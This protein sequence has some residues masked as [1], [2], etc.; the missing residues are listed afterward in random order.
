MK[1]IARK[2]TVATLVTLAVVA[3]ASHCSASPESE[4][5]RADAKAVLEKTEDKARDVVEQGKVLAKKS[6]EKSGEIAPNVIAKVKAGAH[7]AGEV[8]TDMAGKVEEKIS[9]LTK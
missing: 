5:T 9:A 1:M 3:L 4:Q 2:F 7:K 6:A 8:V